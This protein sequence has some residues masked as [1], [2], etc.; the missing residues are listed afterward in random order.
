MVSIWEKETFFAPQDVIIIGSG[1]VGLWS[2]FY[3]KK[4]NPELKI[5]II[6]GGLIPTGAS[7]RNAGFACFGSLSEIIYDAKT[8]GTEKMLQLVEMRF[9]GLER[10]IKHFSEN[11]IDFSLCGGYELYD[12]SDAVTG[13]Q[14][15]HNIEY[16]NS[17]LKPITKTKKTYKLADNK[18][19]G[20]GFGSTAHLVKNNL[21]GYLHSGKLLQCLLSRIQ[22]MGVTV[23]NNLKSCSFESDG[24]LKTISTNQQVSLQTKKILLCTNAFTKQLI[25]DIDITPARGQVLLTSPIN[26]LPFKGSFHSDE[27]FYYF[28]N[29]DNK[30]L[31]G[32]ARNKAFDEESTSD[33]TLTPTIQ[34]ELER[35]LKEVILPWTND[36]T[37]EYRWSGIMAMGSEKMPIVKELQPNVYCAVRMSGM[38]VAL[39]PIVSQQV[40]EM[41]FD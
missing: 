19:A 3:L 33:L 7:T 28:R 2:A 12:A 13:D 25:D 15:I 18:I 29:L 34:S 24:E 5:T 1:F 38:G 30:V 26:N 36:Y 9:K 11:D 16:V 6:E 17:I 27:G 21:E 20:F 8:M 4:K 32:G 39:A 41:M 22:G 10:I 40:A 35:Y 14:L 37:I 31:L 23:L